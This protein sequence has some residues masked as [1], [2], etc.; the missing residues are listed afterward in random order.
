[1]GGNR[2]WR[3]TFL[4]Q[5]CTWWNGFIEVQQRVKRKLTF[6][7]RTYI[8]YDLSQ[9]KYV[10]WKFMTFVSKSVGDSCW[11]KIRNNIP[12]FLR[13]IFYDSPI[14]SCISDYRISFSKVCSTLTLSQ[15]T[16]KYG[17]ADQEQIPEFS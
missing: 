2:V 3:Q 9:K 5:I 10:K 11:H 7:S 15:I 1:M 6:Y 14:Q 13:K 16:S 17:P 4:K 8:F 12:V